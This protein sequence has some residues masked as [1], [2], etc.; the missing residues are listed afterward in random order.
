M[1]QYCTVA[2]VTRIARFNESVPL[3]DAVPLIWRIGLDIGIGLGI[4]MAGMS[5]GGI[6]GT[7]WLV[8]QVWMLRMFFRMHLKPAG[9]SPGQPLLIVQ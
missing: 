2:Q 6:G 3:V 5:N 4:G 1:V 8:L 9:V 7:C